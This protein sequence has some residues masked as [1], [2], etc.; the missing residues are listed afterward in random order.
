MP[1]GATATVFVPARVAADVTESGGPAARAMG[2]R[3]LRA[4]FGAAV[5][6]VESGRYGFAVPE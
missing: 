5:F 1:A 6:A 4:E 3:L 2:V